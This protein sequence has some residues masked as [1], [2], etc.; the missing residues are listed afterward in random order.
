MKT[1]SAALLSLFLCTGALADPATQPSNTLVAKRI[2]DP[3]RDSIGDYTIPS[4]L[5]QHVQDLSKQLKMPKRAP[6]DWYNEDWYTDPDGRSRVSLSVNLTGHEGARPLAKEFLDALIPAVEKEMTQNYERDKAKRLQSAQQ[7]RQETRAKLQQTTDRFEQLRAKVRELAHRTD[8][9]PDTI[10]QT[11]GK[12]EDE[13][14]RLELDH[15]GK[16]ARREALETQIARQSRMI[17]DKVNNDPI[18]EEL[19]KSVDLNEAKMEEVKKQVAAGLL[20]RDQ[21]NVSIIAAAEARA[22]LLQ[23]K[24]DAATEGGGETLEAFNRELL[25]LSID[26]HE[27][28]A[29]LEFINSRLPGLR[30]ARDAMGTLMEAD[31]ERAMAFNA[32]ESADEELKKVEKQTSASTPPK[33]VVLESEDGESANP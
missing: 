6:A 26:L 22:R 8:V 1:M 29:R 19:K 7:Q 20:P 31:R 32:A 30:E 33:L 3:V 28:D 13:Q 15:A 4:L 18:L 21:A 23:R 25:T 2:I 24:R 17:E 27:L 11:L 16:A 12:L 14:Q 5:R 10:N 9:T